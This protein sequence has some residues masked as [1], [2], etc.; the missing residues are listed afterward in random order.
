MH[1]NTLSNNKAFIYRARARQLQTQSRRKPKKKQEEGGVALA[2][3]QTSCWGGYESTAHQCWFLTNDSKEQREG[4]TANMPQCRS[5]RAPRWRVRRHLFRVMGGGL[6]KWRTKDK[7][8]GQEIMFSTIQSLSRVQNQ[9]WL[10]STDAAM[11][12][13]LYECSNGGIWQ[14]TLEYVVIQL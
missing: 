5:R 7:K 14:V 11:F 8:W 9:M 2:D 12:I 6:V 10:W 4:Q 3:R 13:L 1:K